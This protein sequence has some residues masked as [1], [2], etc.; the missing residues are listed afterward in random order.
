MHTSL[1]ETLGS[2]TERVRSS[3][4]SGLISF[5]ITR[6]FNFCPFPLKKKMKKIRKR[7]S[8]IG[9]LKKKK[10]KFLFH[11]KKFWNVNF[12]VLS[13]HEG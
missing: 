2:V 3:F 12:C 5:F 8:N 7:S 6:V 1:T 4:H 13:N 11:F 10:L 9:Y